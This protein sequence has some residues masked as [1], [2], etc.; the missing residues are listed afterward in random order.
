[1]LFLAIVGTRPGISY[2]SVYYLTAAESLHATGRLTTPIATHAAVQFA[3]DGTLIREHP[4]VTWPPGFPLALAAGRALGLDIERAVVAVNAVALIVLVFA[5]LQMAR[6]VLPPGRAALVAMC[7]GLLPATQSVARMAWSEMLFVAIAA[8][9]LLNV[10]RW[11]AAR[12]VNVRHHWLA[13]GIWAG[14]AGLVRYAAPML[15]ITQSAAALMYGWRGRTT[16]ERRRVVA[17]LLVGPLMAAAWLVVRAVVFQCWPCDTRSADVT[18]P[19]RHLKDMLF[20][21]ITVVPVIRAWPGWFDSLAS[22]GVLA[23]LAAW[24]AR[25]RQPVRAP[26]PVFLVVATFA[27]CY[28]IVL[29]IVRT[30][31]Y[32][33]QIDARLLSPVVILGSVA[34]LLFVFQRL[35]DGAG[36][37]GAALAIWLALTTLADSVSPTMRWRTFNDAALRNEPLSRA[38]QEAT[39][40][41]AVFVTDEVPRL[42]W[43]TRHPAYWM[44]SSDLLRRFAASHELVVLLRDVASPGAEVSAWLNGAA[45]RT[46]AGDGYTMWWIAARPQSARSP[47]AR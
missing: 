44:P 3:G 8:M 24:F 18:N 7:V 19:L 28:A 16:P 14:V 26:A 38:A 30:L 39:D 1:M 37:F 34:G 21:A 9:S 36:G 27:S 4:F 22:A 29:M 35:R 42:T 31:T 47:D 40:M 23:A 17:G 20:A 45:T 5:S 25:R 33:D 12:G 10:V 6:T 15:F 13:A 32:F 46:D 2:D 41:R 43:H 11:I